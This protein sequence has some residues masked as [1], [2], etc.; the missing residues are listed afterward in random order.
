[1]KT[2]EF[3]VFCTELNSPL[4]S[5]CLKL[6]FPISLLWNTGTRPPIIAVLQETWFRHREGVRMTHQTE[7]VI[8][9]HAQRHILLMLKDFQW[10]EYRAVQ[11]SKVSWVTVW[12][13]CLIQRCPPT[14]VLCKF[15]F[16]WVFFVMFCP[17]PPPFFFFNFIFILL[18]SYFFCLV[19]LRDHKKSLAW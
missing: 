17:P 13:G 10:W 12:C 6:Q 8:S 14:R 16:G 5:L 9:S 19:L 4:C 18:N 11:V 2:H 3:G 15:L 7:K 1:M